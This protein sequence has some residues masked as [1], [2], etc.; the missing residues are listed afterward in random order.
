M[1]RGVKF[2]GRDLNNPGRRQPIALLL[3]YKS[4]GICKLTV[5]GLPFPTGL[6]LGWLGWS[7]YRRRTAGQSAAASAPSGDHQTCK[8]S[9]W[10]SGL[11]THAPT[12][13]RWSVDSAAAPTADQSSLQPSRLQATEQAVIGS[14]K[15]IYVCWCG[16]GPFMWLVE[17][18][19]SLF[20][21]KK[22]L[23]SLRV[24]VGVGSNNRVGDFELPIKMVYIVGEF[25]RWSLLSWTKN[26]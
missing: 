8:R 2:L 6:E 15:V 9:D 19:Y 16:C 26:S 22:G 5:F 7:A 21:K 14:T 24:D 4:L 12:L 20:L 10:F 3:L 13:N 1:W 18:K 17:A 23:K 11:P 25:V